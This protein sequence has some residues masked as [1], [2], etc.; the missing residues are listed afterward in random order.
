V[1]VLQHGMSV[2]EIVNLTAITAVMVEQNGRGAGIA[3]E[4]VT[5]GA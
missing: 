3:T 5:L 4:A 2:A 1:S